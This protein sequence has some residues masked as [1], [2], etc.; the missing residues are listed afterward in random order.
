MILFADIN[1]KRLQVAKDL[2][3]DATYL[4]PAGTDAVT[5]AGHVEAIFGGQLP[6][7]TLEC[8]G[9]ESSVNLAILVRMVKYPKSL[10]YKINE[11]NHFFLLQATR[12]NGKVVIVG[13]YWNMKQ[14]Y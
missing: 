3:A 5:Q 14:F 12:A 11:L 10:L 7:I 1:D 8:S 13:N 2:G 9:A 4:V 6:D